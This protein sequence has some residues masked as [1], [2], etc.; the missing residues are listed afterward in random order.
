[1]TTRKLFARLRIRFAIHLAR[2]INYYESGDVNRFD[3][4]VDSRGKVTATCATHIKNIKG[5]VFDTDV[6]QYYPATCHMLANW[7]QKRN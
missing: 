4:M 3:R 7:L 1:M 6:N 5:I 2:D